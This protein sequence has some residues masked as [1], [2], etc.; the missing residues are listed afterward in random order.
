LFAQLN[1]KVVMKKVLRHCLQGSTRTT[2]RDRGMTLIE[3]LVVITIVGI[4]A[5][6]ALPALFGQV[7]KAKEVE[8]VQTVRYLGDR[9]KE[10]YLENSHFT[11][12]LNELGSSFPNNPDSSSICFL[13]AMGF[14]YQQTQSYCYGVKTVEDSES[15]IV[16]HIALANHADVASHVGVVYLKNAD[17][18]PCHP[19][20]IPGCSSESLSTCIQFL[21]KIWN[22]S[23]GI[24]SDSN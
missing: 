8:A 1:K 5:A 20:R 16:L 10:F 23:S 11:E 15:T 2:D 24:C 13:G 4:L 21:S 14:S 9:Q 3:L 18:I 12:S 22:D 7:A 17:I 19:V 6:I